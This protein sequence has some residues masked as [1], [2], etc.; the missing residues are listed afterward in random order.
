MKTHFVQARI[1]ASWHHGV[2]SLPSRSRKCTLH[3]SITPLLQR[4]DEEAAILA[5]FSPQTLHLVLG[6]SISCIS[7]NSI[8]IESI[9][10]SRKAIAAIA[11]GL[12]DTI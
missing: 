2:P 6:I 7:I 4:N 11:A 5:H 12:V 10:S 8:A 9:M 1:A 3:D